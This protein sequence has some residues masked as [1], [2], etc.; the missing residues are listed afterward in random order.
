MGSDPRYIFHCCDIMADLAASCNDTILVIN[1]GITGSE[2][3]HGN[4]GVRGI[5]YSSIL[6]YVDSKQMVKNICASQKYTSWSYFL[7]L[8]EKTNILEKLLFGNV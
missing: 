7:T 4:L 6:V 3:K 1:R 8:T 2:D 5:G